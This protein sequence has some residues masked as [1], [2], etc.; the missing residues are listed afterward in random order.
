MGRF[1]DLQ[2]LIDSVG[3]DELVQVAGEGAWNTPEGRS[4]D[5]TAIDTA[6]GYADDLIAGYVL[7]RNPW[8]RGVDLADAP[9]L[10]RGLALDIVRYRLR[11]QTGAKG[12]ITDTVKD[13][14]DAAM[15]TL[16][17]ISRGN[18]DL[19][20]ERSGEPTPI[21]SAQDSVRIAGGEPTAG[22][23]VEDFLR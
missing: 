13:R 22:P 10:L 14:Y 21:S 6:I 2:S 11:N 9:D 3:E 7:G 23:L 8:L 17:D 19:V 1:I 18:V 12:Q 20:D 5:V 4:L 15:M 16:R